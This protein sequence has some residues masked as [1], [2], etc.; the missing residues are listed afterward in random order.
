MHGLEEHSTAARTKWNFHPATNHLQGYSNP[1]PHNLV[2][3]EGNKI[4]TQSTTRD[5]SKGKT[6]L[7]PQTVGVSKNKPKA[8]LYNELSILIT[9]YLLKTYHQ[10]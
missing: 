2:N 3:K 8:L 4:Y 1:T 9:F 6:P 10:S 7:Y 5:P